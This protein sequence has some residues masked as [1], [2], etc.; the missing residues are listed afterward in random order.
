MLCDCTGGAIEITLPSASAIVGKIY[1]IKK[2]D[3]SAN[4]V[5]ITQA[6]A[7]TIDGAANASLTIQ[8]EDLSFI[9]DGTDWFIL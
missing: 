4:A 2:I 9:S 3:S 6:G 7:D 1:D 5:T 8:W